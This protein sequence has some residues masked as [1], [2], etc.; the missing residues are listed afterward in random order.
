MPVVNQLFAGWLG[1]FT[2]RNFGFPKVSAVLREKGDL[3][4]NKHLGTHGFLERRMFWENLTL[5]RTNQGSVDR[6]IFHPHCVC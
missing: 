1:M 3:A 4:H 6:V 5:C 2:S